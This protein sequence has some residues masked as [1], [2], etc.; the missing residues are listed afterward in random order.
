MR[1][2]S[3][4]MGLPRAPTKIQ[5]RSNHTLTIHYIDHNSTYRFLLIILNV[6]ATVDVGTPGHRAKTARYPNHNA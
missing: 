1:I 6:H 4:G 2:A 3:Q 5:A